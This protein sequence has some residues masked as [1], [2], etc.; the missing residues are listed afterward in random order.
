MM[1]EKEYVLLDRI[2]IQSKEINNLIADNSKLIVENEELRR[3]C[4]QYREALE[5]IWQ[6][7]MEYEEIIEFIWKLLWEKKIQEQDKG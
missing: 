5:T 2:E 4:E 6:G 7:D 3:K 1:Q